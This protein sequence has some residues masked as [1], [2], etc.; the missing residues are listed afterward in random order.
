MVG[1]SRCALSQLR[2]PKAQL[3]R[4]FS[5]IPSRAYSAPS[6]SIP[7]AKKKYIPTSGTYPLGFQVS[8]TIVGVKPSNTTKPDLALLTSEVPCAAAAVFTKNK[9]QA[10]PVTFSRALLQKKGNKGI[11]GVVINSGCANAV[12]GK[13]GL[14]DAAKMAQA[15]DKCLGQSDSIIVM[16]TGV[17]GQRLPIDKIINNVPKAHS[18]LGGS[19]EHWLTMAKAICTTDTFPKLISR[20]FTLPSSPGVEYRIAGT[21]KG[22][23]M[24]HP[25]MA[26]LLGVIATDAPISSSALPSVLKHAVDRSFNSIT[27]DGD[28]S[29]NDTVALLANGMAGGKEVVEGTPDY[30]AFREVLTKFSTE[31]AQLIVRDGEGATK[32]V[33]IKVVDSASEEAARKIASTIARSPLVKTALYG[34]DANWGRI[35][36]ATGYSLI[37]EPSEPINDVPEIVPENTNVS[38]VP[39]DGTAELKL[40]VNG[41]PEQVDE[42]RAAEILELEDL[43]ILVR[44]GTGDKQATYW[45]CDYSHEYITINGDYRT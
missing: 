8:G 29:T 17:I 45:T 38:F 26:T 30:E 36:C 41:E 24:I 42:A 2:Q 40:L 13:G 18:A 23:G 25:N 12:T 34:K 19:H 27:I 10:A 28:T 31:L 6:S 35:L 32:F 16:S 7:A 11:Q 22:A 15:A 39:T 5:H 4:S 37:S 9:F 14:E 3:V 21:T 43:E 33:T 20:T 1:F 44:L